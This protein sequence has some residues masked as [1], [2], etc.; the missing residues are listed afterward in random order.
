MRSLLLALLLSGACAAPTSLHLKVAD[1]ATEDAH[2]IATLVLNRLA[3]HAPVAGNV[4]VDFVDLDV[5]SPAL[6][7]RTQRMGFY[8]WIIELDDDLEG[9]FLAKVI[10]HEWAHVLAKDAGCIGE[11]SHSAYWGVAYA[12]A[13]RAS[14]MPLSSES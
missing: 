1:G 11:D 10:I 8:S 12:Q 3:V 5:F 4:S 14:W 7:G 6:A 9:Q 2:E 13:Y